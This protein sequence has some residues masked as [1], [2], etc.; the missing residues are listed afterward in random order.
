MPFISN[1]VTSILEFHVSGC[2]DMCRVWSS[3]KATKGKVNF[4]VKLFT[5]VSSLK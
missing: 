1:L 2:G 5:I 4:R 3:Y